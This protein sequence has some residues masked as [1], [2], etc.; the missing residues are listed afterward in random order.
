[1]IAI[2]LLTIESDTRYA[3]LVRQLGDR[4]FIQAQLDPGFSVNG[5]SPVRKKLG[6]PEKCD[7]FFAWNAIALRDEQI[8]NGPCPDCERFRGDTA[9]SLGHGPVIRQPWR[10]CPQWENVR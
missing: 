7:S 5:Q 10:G 8:F 2:G 4:N 9:I 6:I 3:R 1:M